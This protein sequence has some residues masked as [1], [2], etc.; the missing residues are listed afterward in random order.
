MRNLETYFIN[1][2]EMVEAPTLTNKASLDVISTRAITSVVMDEFAEYGKFQ[3]MQKYVVKNDEIETIRTRAGYKTTTQ[4]IIL[5]YI[6]T[7]E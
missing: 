6:V 7:Q 4:V 5:R 2:Y 3:Y 1:D